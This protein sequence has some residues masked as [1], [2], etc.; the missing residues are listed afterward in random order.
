LPFVL[1]WPDQIV[2]VNSWRK[3]TLAKKKNEEEGFSKKWLEVISAV[4]ILE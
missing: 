2:C 4:L 1:F 3:V